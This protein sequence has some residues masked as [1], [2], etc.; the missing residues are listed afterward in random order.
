MKDS[1][2]IGA[3]LSKKGALLFVI[4]FAAM[5]SPCFP[6][7]AKDIKEAFEK[8]IESVEV[9]KQEE[10]EKLK[11]ELESK[12]SLAVKEWLAREDKKDEPALNKII[13]QEWEKLPEFGPRIHYD[14]YLRGYAYSE[15][16]TDILQTNSLTLPYKAHLNAVKELY[17]ERGHSPDVTSAQ[18]F[19][20]T[21]SIPFRIDF[22]YREGRFVFVNSEQQKIT[23]KQGW[24]EAIRKGR[25]F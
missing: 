15:I 14:Y 7:Q 21:V 2:I 19:L 8:A 5:L 23:L 12:L 10:Q 9:K 4:F 20:Y 17:V 22:E 11:E 25:Y 6:Q 13:K 1:S 18:K 3:M 16:K 24:P